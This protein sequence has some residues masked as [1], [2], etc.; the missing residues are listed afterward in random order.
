MDVPWGDRITPNG[1]IPLPGNNL[2]LLFECGVSSSEHFTWR[3]TP[4]GGGDRAP[5]E[6]G[7][8]LALQ[9][10]TFQE[11]GRQ[12]LRNRGVN[13]RIQMV[14]TAEERVK[15]GEGL[16]AVGGQRQTF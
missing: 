3:G 14:R 1:E 10:L 6:R 11:G 2:Q 8:G 9:N 15:Q 16:T 7:R 4:A 13:L 5:S 12:R